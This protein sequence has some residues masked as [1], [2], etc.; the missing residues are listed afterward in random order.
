M[1]QGAD[2]VTRIFDRV[3]ADVYSDADIERLRRLTVS[4]D[5]NVVQ[6]GRHNV[7]IRHGR[8]IHVG[9]RIYRGPEADV[10]RAVL[11]QA[12]IDG[13]ITNG[14]PRGGLRSL[15]GVVF[16]V[17]TMIALVGMALF[18]YGLVSSMMVGLN[19][20]PRGFDS[21]TFVGFGIGVVGSL[22][23]SFGQLLRGWERPRG[24]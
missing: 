7:N 21:V 18:A 14:L 8:D 13:P 17:G 15:S 3:A 1:G 5:Q 16:T 20:G 22:L 11:Q 23:A 6:I 10:I 9:D 2:E 4:G 19:E 12:L 24:R